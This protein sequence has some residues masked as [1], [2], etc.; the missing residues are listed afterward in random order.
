MDGKLREAAEDYDLDPVEQE[1]AEN[2][3]YKFRPD[4]TF[5]NV[6]EY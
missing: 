6:P 4:V 1:F 2:E 3:N 5:Y